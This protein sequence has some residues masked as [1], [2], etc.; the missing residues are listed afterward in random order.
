MLNQ[1]HTILAVDDEPGTLRLIERVLHKHFRLLTAPDG[2]TALQI[3]RQNDISLVITDQRMPGML[4]T[5]LLRECQAINP[6]MVSLVV[7][8][9]N[10]YNTVIE[11]IQNSGAIRVI[12]KPWDPDQM[13]QTVQEALAKYERAVEN[14]RTM[15]KLKQVSDN[16]GQIS[17][18]R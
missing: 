8:A 18:R 10:D 11:A 17:K 6:D 16:L 15:S 13:L 12:N 5:E 14:K 4:G 9:N 1:D 2:E 7:T 3:V